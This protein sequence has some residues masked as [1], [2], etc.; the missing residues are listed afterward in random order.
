[1]RFGFRAVPGTA[2]PGHHAGG[3]IELAPMMLSDFRTL[4]RETLA[5]PRAKYWRPETMPGL[6]LPMPRYA[7]LSPSDRDRSARRHYSP[8]VYRPSL[9]FNPHWPDL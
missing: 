6:W 5:A 8:P 3:R 1:M 9:G 2:C 4:R 7:I